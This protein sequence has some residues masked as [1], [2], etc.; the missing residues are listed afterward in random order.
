MAASNRFLHLSLCLLF[1]TSSTFSKGV[2]IPK[3]PLGYVYGNGKPTA[4]IHLEAFVDLTCPDCQ[5]A[6]PTIK[7]VAKLY[8]PDTI[9][10]LVQPFPLPYHTNAFI[11]AQSVPV[12]ASYNSSL[13]FT[14]IDVLFKFQSEL[15]NFQTMNKNRYDILNI[16]S[17]LAPKAGVPSD[18][19]KTGLTG[20]ESDGAA[21]IGWKHGCLR[22]V[23]GTPTFFINGI[24]VEADSSWT[25][26]QWK[27]VIDPL[28]K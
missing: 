17:S 1:T 24:P 20:T 12:V 19:M 10:V 2:P 21:R 11:A 13:V 8:G 4:P 5:Q 22:T 26:Q 15:Y 23:A 25:V 14:W 7:Q 27:D 16:V 3:K 6:W 28:L 9:L 18:I